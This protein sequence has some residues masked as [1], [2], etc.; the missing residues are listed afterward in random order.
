MSPAGSGKYTCV[1]LLLLRLVLLGLLAV[2]VARR[3]VVAGVSVQR[4]ATIV[5]V[6]VMV[7][8][9]VVGHG[10]VGGRGGRSGSPLQAGAAAGEGWG[11]KAGSR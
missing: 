5:A 6:A 10:P 9:S 11:V 4:W 1:L 3:W 7:L 8:V 2:G